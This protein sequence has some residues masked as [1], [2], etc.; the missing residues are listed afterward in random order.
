MNAPAKIPES[1]TALVAVR[2]VGH[3]FEAFDT[4]GVSLGVAVDGAQL[5]VLLNKAVS[6]VTEDI[7][8]PT[9]EQV[10]LENMVRET[11]AAV[12]TFLE[13][14]HPGVTKLAKTFLRGATIAQRK[15]YFED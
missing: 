6:S 15:G 14:R 5:W 11:G 1:K 13:Q 8:L 7:Q 12:G 4:E 2:R 9:P 10:T 3:T